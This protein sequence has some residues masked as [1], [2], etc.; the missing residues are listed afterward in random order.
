MSKS[1][2]KKQGFVVSKPGDKTIKV[3]VKSRKQHSFY[4]KV[5]NVTWSGLVHDENN[6]AKVGDEVIFCACRPLSAKKSW[7]LLEILGEKS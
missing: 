1:S 2:Q 3:S 7:R 5:I 4:K 6:E